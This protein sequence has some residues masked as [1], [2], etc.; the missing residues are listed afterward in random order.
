MEPS[1]RIGHKTGRLQIVDA[2]G[3]EHGWSIHT[4]SDRHGNEGLALDV[5]YG[6]LYVPKLNR[7][8]DSCGANVPWKKNSNP[9]Q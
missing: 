9:E 4:F 5:S 3:E 7:V 6:L 2:N 1:A 8:L